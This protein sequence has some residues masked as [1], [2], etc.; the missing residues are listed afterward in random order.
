MQQS[1]SDEKKPIIKIKKT[2]NNG[3][4]KGITGWII[5]IV[6]A[7]IVVAAIVYGLSYLNTQNT[8]ENIAEDQLSD[9]PIDVLSMLSKH[10]VLPDGESNI[11]VIEDVETLKQQQPFFALANNDDQ[12]IVYSDQAIIYR[13]STDMIIKV[14]AVQTEEAAEPLSDVSLTFD[15]R[16][17]TT[18]AGQAGILA[19]QIRAVELFEVVNV[20]DANKKDYATTVIYDLTEGEKQDAI[21]VFAQT[22]GLELVEGF[23]EGELES[24]A[25]VL[26]ILGQ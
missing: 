23:P 7:I 12:L 6:I 14:G 15:I 8:D 24:E 18:V 1:K 25:E 19:D 10:M 5:A 2:E 3:K 4:E 26:I 20:G 22:L 17:G 16:N 9:A 21:A 13:P 11:I